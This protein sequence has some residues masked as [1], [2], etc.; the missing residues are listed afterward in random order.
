MFFQDIGEDILLE[1]LCL[2]DIYVV[3]SVSTVNKFFRRV[4]LSKQLWLHLMQDLVSRGVL[5]RLSR[6]ELD[7][8]STGDIIDEIKRIVCGPTTWAPTSSS[9]PTVH[10]QLTFHTGVNRNDIFDLMLTP[11]GTHAILKTIGNVRLYDVRTGRCLWTKAG[12]QP[13]IATDL[14]ESGN[15]LRILLVPGNYSENAN[16]TIEEVNLATGE[17]HEVFSFPLPPDSGSSL[18]WC[19]DLRENFLILH[20]YAVPLPG[21]HI[22]ILVDWC[23]R[24]QVL[25]TYEQRNGDLRPR[26]L[27]DHILVTYN[28]LTPSG[29]ARP[30]LIA[31]T[32]FT[33][34]EAYW[35]PLNVDSTTMEFSESESI[36]FSFPLNPQ[37]PSKYIPIT[38]VTGLQLQNKPIHAH[39]CYSFFVYE[40]PVHHDTYRIMMLL[41]S[42]SYP[43]TPENRVLLTYT[44]FTPNPSSDTPPRFQ[45]GTPCN[46]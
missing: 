17:S 9:E 46:I 7:A 16:V 10:R 18:W 29:Q 21:G 38:A 22:F 36:I 34:L 25:L 4:A 12:D 15:I 30:Y 35:H 27:R 5:Y 3:L 44:L 33:A 6:A 43:F 42:N 45:P 14:V 40:N 32:A 20:L 26:L 39:D 24:K 31:V 23:K 37:A 8:Y 19:S 11:G 1:I 28:Q 13:S 2:C 41:G